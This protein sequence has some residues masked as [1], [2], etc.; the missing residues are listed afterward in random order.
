MI[1]GMNRRGLLRCGAW[2]G[3]GLL[4]T[5]NGGVPHSWLLGDANAATEGLTFVQISDTH[6]GFNKPANPDTKATMSAAVD[7]IAAL[8]PKPA[9]LI[10]TG[11]ITHLS[12]PEEFDT[13][14]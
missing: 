12:K 11:D 6:I 5:V 10:H 3:A 13:A 7:R 2:A 1:D 8:S 14:L 9:F 4:W